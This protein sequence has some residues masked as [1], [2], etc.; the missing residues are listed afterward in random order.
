MLCVGTALHPPRQRRSP[1]VTQYGSRPVIL[2][3]ES[4]AA[5]TL[6]VGQGTREKSEVFCDSMTEDS[7]GVY[8]S[9]ERPDGFDR[10][11][12]VTLAYGLDRSDCVGFRNEQCPILDVVCNI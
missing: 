4:S 2:K 7:A 6:S 3:A 12:L 1:A 9:Q 8:Q 5:S 10:P 11:D